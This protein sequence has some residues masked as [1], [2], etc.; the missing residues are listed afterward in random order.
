[1]LSNHSGSYMLNEV[2]NVFFDL[3]MNEKVGKEVTVEFAKRLVELG[4]SHDC[5][6]GEILE[7]FDKKIR[8]CYICLKE[9]DELENGL[10]PSC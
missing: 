7:G 6:P 3:K 2:L 10:C 1:V 5:N 9:S 4:D 8:L